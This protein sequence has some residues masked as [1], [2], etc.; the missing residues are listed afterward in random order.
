MTA[1]GDSQRFEA[2]QARVDALRAARAPKRNPSADKFTAGALAWR[3]VTELVVGVLMGAGIGW[4]IDVFLATKPLFLLIFGLLGF[5]AGIRTVMRS[6]D[7]VRR[8][9]AAG[10]S[11]PGAA[12][13]ADSNTARAAEQ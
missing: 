13:A 11:A 9:D 3:M 10:Q 7:E 5:A 4:G 8:R 6:A 1:E 2:L 12:R